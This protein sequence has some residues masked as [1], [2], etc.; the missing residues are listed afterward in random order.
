MHRVKDSHFHFAVYYSVCIHTCMCASKLT[1]VHETIRETGE[2]FGSECQEMKQKLLPLF[3]RPKEG[4]LL[5]P[6]SREVVVGE[7]GC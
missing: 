3:L 4:V 6:L 1:G 5:V 7:E 2:V